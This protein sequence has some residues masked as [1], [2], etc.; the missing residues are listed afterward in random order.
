MMSHSS[1]AVFDLLTYS[2]YDS[3]WEEITEVEDATTVTDAEVAAR[4]KLDV[5]TTRVLF[6]NPTWRVLDGPIRER[7]VLPASGSILPGNYPCQALARKVG[8]EK[9]YES[10][11][12]RMYIIRPSQGHGVASSMLGYDG[13]ADPLIDYLGR[14]G[15]RSILGREKE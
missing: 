1:C 14:L 10:C 8:D 11:Y 9:M 13:I 6:E 12:I 7:H 3:T 15:S 4:S 5:I 2:D